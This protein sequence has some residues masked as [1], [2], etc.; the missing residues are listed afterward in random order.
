MSIITFLETQYTYKPEIKS[1]R[2]YFGTN[3]KKCFLICLQKYNTF[4]L[5]KRQIIK[6]MQTN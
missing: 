2:C 1:R 6:C 4:K 5:Y 3:N